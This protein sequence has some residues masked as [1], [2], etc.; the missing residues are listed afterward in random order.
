VATPSVA[1]CSNRAWARPAPRKI[2]IQ[3]FESFFIHDGTGARATRHDVK[4]LGGGIAEARPFRQVSA[5]GIAG[6][7]KVGPIGPQHCG[8]RLILR[9]RSRPVVFSQ[10]SKHIRELFTVWSTEPRAGGIGGIAGVLIKVIEKYPALSS[11]C[12]QTCP[13][14]RL[15]AE[16]RITREVAGGLLRSRRFSARIRDEELVSE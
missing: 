13:G 11:L 10:L 1:N 9:R 2:L 8:Q 7:G 14:P 4:H 15:P 3:C 6:L 5:V 16:R 12:L